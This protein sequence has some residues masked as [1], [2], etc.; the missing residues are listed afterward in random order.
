MNPDPSGSSA[1][2]YLWLC[3]VASVLLTSC[4]GP[5]LRSQFHSLNTAYAGALNEQMLLNL[6]RLENGH[7]AYYLAIGPI[8]NRFTFSSETSAGGTG[9]TT[10]SKTTAAKSQGSSTSGGVLNLVERT[11][12]SVG[13]TVLGASFGEKFTG[14]SNPDFQFIPLN[15]ETVA[16]QVLE[17]ISTDVFFTLYQQGAPIDQLLRILI[18][19]IETTLANKEEVMLVNSPTRG[20]PDSYARFLKTCAILREMQRRGVLVLETRRD[21]EA[22]GLTSFGGPQSGEKFH[23]T[24]EQLTKAEDQGYTWRRDPNGAWQI[25]RNRA[26]P[27]FFLKS[28]DLE[29]VARQVTETKAIDDPKAITNVVELLR[30]G[31]TVKIRPE[32]GGQAN[33]RLVLRSFARAMEAVA[34]EQAGFDF[35]MKNSDFYAHVPASERQP[36]LRLVWSHDNRNLASP[37]QTLR[38][39]AKT[40][41]ITDPIADPLD[42][43]ESWNRDVFRLMVALASQVTVDISKFQRQV[44]ELR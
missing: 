9:S 1:R 5:V 37:V 23:P 30:D 19:R 12:T 10:D 40:Y 28:A 44:L 36:I 7:P 15:N 39:A 20:T 34:S 18:E 42:P 22:F 2:R 13:S 6:A 24:P 31:I 43:S 3:L 32:G 38:Y 4:T 27:T 41:Q 35:L 8:N 11:V 21:F 29:K 14:T 16:K 26:V 25:G 33:T 17:P